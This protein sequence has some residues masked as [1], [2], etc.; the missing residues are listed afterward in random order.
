MDSSQRGVRFH[1]YPDGEDMEDDRARNATPAPPRSA[2]SSVS[3]LHPP[4]SPRPR[5]TIPGPSRE[6]SSTMPRSA[7]LGYFPA[8]P[9]IDYNVPS[10][11]EEGGFPFE[12]PIA[13]GLSNYAWSQLSPAGATPY[14]TSG[15]PYVPSY[16]PD[17]IQH[18]DTERSPP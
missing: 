10:I 9:P 7:A 18:N 2:A 6:T 17:G 8:E 13:N 14:Y 4:Q 12:T 1:G 11:V 3:S 5:T 16:E 15:P